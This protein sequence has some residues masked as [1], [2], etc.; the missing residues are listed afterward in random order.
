MRQLLL[1][2]LGGAVGSG[3]RFLLS[4]AIVR[5]VS[6][7]GAFPWGTLSVNLLGCFVF[8]FLVAALATIFA[9]SPALRLALLTGILGG[10]TTY[11]AFNGEVLALARAGATATVA[12]YVAATLLGAVA[13][14]IG[15][16]FAGQI[17]GRSLGGA[18]A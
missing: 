16:A 10:F 11:S 12:L 4:S 7:P 13:V 3:A 15:G 18:G 17:V 9:T 8:E 1:V 6:G 5:G 2:C 14:G